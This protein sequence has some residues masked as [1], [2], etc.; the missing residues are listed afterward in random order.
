MQGNPTHNAFHR[1]VRVS[2]R[3]AQPE[4]QTEIW[5][6][7]QGHLRQADDYSY[8]SSV[9]MLLLLL[10]CYVSI[11]EACLLPSGRQEGKPLLHSG[12]LMAVQVLFIVHNLAISWSSDECFL[13]ISMTEEVLI[14]ISNLWISHHRMHWSNYIM[15]NEQC[16]NKLQQVQVN[17]SQL[18]LV[19]VNDVSGRNNIPETFAG[20][21]FMCFLYILEDL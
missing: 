5:C 16:L 10:K 11:W 7:A 15:Q 12:N 1:E 6:L 14:F 3:E 4:E 13:V 19:K 21:R 8:S 2:C 20:F 18:L 17:C 9:W